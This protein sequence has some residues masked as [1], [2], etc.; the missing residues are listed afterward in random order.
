MRNPAIMAVAVKLVLTVPAIGAEPIVLECD[1]PKIVSPERRM[2]WERQHFVFYI[3]ETWQVTDY[4]YDWDGHVGS[5]SAFVS[6]SRNSGIITL[7]TPRAIPDGKPLLRIGECK[8]IT[9][10]GNQF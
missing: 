6:I 9:K 10:A 5:M 1:L 2:T 4:T 7:K 3:D 8:R